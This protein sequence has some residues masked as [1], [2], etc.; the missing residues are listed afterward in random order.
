VN[1]RELIE[2]LKRLAALLPPETPVEVVH[3]EGH[4]IGKIIGVSAEL[5]TAR[6]DGQ[7]TV[8]V[9]LEE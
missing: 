4:V 3:N 5:G 7:T 8:L 9:D 1:L 2:R 6:E